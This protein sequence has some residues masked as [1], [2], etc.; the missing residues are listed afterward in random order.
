MRAYVRNKGAVVGATV[1]V[2][3][4]IIAA[5]AGWLFPFSPWESPTGWVSRLPQF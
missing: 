4:G 3:V 2:L 5:L 1:V